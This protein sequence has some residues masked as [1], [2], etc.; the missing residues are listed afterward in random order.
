MNNKIENALHAA[1]VCHKHQFDKAG[2][3]Y[4]YHPLRVMFSMETEEEKVLALMHDCPEDNIKVWNNIIRPI[5]IIHNMEED[6]LNAESMAK[7]KKEHYMDYIKR[8]SWSPLLRRVKLQDIYDNSDPERLAKLKE[9][10]RERLRNKYYP[11]IEFL[12]ESNN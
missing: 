7:R 6:I 4:I 11:A 12:L 10:E 9:K 2:Q 5:L 3:P 8:L 1:Y